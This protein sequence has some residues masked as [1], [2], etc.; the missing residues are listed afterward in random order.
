VLC[1]S[2]VGTVSGLCAGKGLF[3]PPKHQIGSAVHIAIH[4]VD[5]SSPI[6]DVKRTE[7]EADH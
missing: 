5:I 4:S 6:P 2:S 1:G 7:R 3:T